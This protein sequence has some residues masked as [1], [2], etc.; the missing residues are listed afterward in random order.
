MLEHWPKELQIGFPNW[1]VSFCQPWGPIQ[2][3]KVEH[4]LVTW[5]RLLLLLLVFLFQP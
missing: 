4:L 5:G 3:H 2:G 1:M